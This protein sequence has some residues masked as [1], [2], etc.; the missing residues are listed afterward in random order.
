MPDVAESM[1][2]DG[3]KIFK[4]SSEHATVVVLAASDEHEC[5]I[6][7]GDIV[8]ALGLEQS[9]EGLLISVGLG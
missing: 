6:M 3:V 7:R 8:T 4:D 9:V 1:E 5:I 2:G